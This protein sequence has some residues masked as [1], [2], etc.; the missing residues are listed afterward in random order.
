MDMEGQ[1]LILYIAIMIRIDHIKLTKMLCIFSVLNVFAK[2]HI[3][4]SIMV[5]RIHPDSN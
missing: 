5:S 2:V 3:P 4:V 1:G